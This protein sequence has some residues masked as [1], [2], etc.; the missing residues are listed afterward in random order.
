[1]EDCITNITWSRDHVC[2][3]LMNQSNDYIN[4][5]MYIIN[6][7]MQIQSHKNAIIFIQFPFIIFFIY[8]SYRSK[9]GSAITDFISYVFSWDGLYYMQRSL[10]SIFKNYS[11]FYHFLYFFLFIF[12]AHESLSLFAINSKAPCTFA[13]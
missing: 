10:Y 7:M 11:M 12:E 6:I 2:Y 4:T 9:K 8:F 13:N 3:F 5:Y 1:M